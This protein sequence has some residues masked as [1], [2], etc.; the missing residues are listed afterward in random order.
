MKLEKNTTA[1]LILGYEINDPKFKPVLKLAS[2]G[3]KGWKTPTFIEQLITD[4]TPLMLH[5][6]W[7]YDKV[8]VSKALK[9][10]K[11]V[12]VKNTD[13]L[14][15][16]LNSSNRFES[17]DLQQS[18]NTND[19]IDMILGTMVRCGSHDF[20]EA[21]KP[22][23]RTYG[24]YARPNNYQFERMNAGI[25]RILSNKFPNIT[26]LDD[27]LR[28]PVYEYLGTKAYATNQQDTNNIGRIIAANHSPL[29]PIPQFEKDWNPDLFVKIHKSKGADQLRDIIFNFRNQKDIKQHDVERYVDQSKDISRSLAPT[30]NVVYAFAGLSAA[31]ISAAQ[32]ITN[33][34]LYIPSLVLIA[35]TGDQLF[36]TI[37]D[38]FK[39]KDFKWLDVAE[40][41]AQWKY[42][43]NKPK[44]NG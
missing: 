40:Q 17:I 43:T 36:T 12:G 21:I 13:R 44:I 3:E 31:T 5:D 10:L 18:L 4:P 30:R 6:H 42:L 7:L 35:I 19:D 9:Y 34:Y 16:V 25:I 15:Q 39:A 24:T 38:R 32:L 2:K 8:S 23:E 29:T 33:P 37:G 26:P 1:G 20:E 22:L 11:S 27:S 14:S 28:A 41:L